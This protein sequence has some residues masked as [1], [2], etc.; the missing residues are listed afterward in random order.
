[1]YVRM[2]GTSDSVSDLCW[3][4]ALFEFMLEPPTILAGNFLG[5]PQSL[6][7]NISSYFLSNYCSLIIMRLQLYRLNC[8]E[9]T[10]LGSSTTSE[11]QLWRVW[12]LETPFRLLIR[13][14]QS[15][16]R[17]TTRY[18]YN[19]FLRCVTFTQL[20]ISH[21]N[22]PFSHSLHNTLQI[23]PSHFETLA[24]NWLREFTS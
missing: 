19:Y 24:E 21:A 9:R 16:P 13:L 17:V 6:Q 22:I 3:G 10:K 20:A 7:A 2:Y 23:K 18:N 11:H 1:M 8:W 12:V 15:E 5:H 4:S 14:L